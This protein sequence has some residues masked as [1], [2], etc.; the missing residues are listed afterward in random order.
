MSQTVTR[1]T[2]IHAS[3]VSQARHAV[4]RTVGTGAVVLSFWMGLG[5]GE[6]QIAHAQQPA[7][8]TVVLPPGGQAYPQQPYMQPG[9]PGQPVPPGQP[10]QPYY[11]PP[12][13]P[14]PPGY[15][16]PQPYP[17]YPYAQPPYGSAPEQPRVI[18]GWQTKKPHWPLLIAGISVLGGSYLLTAGITGAIQATDCAVNTTR[19]SCSTSGTYWPMYIPVVGPFI[20]MSYISSN[21]WGALAYPGLVFSGLAQSAGLALILAGAIAP[22]KIP[23]Y[24]NDP[25]LSIAPYTTPGGGGV[26]ASGR[27]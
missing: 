14:Y 5:L 19:T 7:A 22:R 13:Q 3:H 26:M 11:A 4:A 8:G 2:R 12:G 17:G 10:G 24:N 21:S 20:E 16:Q 15:S 6:A 9:Q 27:F 25:R 18:T 1:R 23:I